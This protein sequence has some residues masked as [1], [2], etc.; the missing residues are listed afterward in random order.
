MSIYDTIQV[1]SVLTLQYNMIFKL[2][3]ISNNFAIY[4][5]NIYEYKILSLIGIDL[6]IY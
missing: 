4:K 3:L 1:C 6:L 2:R 5:V